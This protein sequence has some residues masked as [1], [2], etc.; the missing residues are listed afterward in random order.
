MFK[1]EDLSLLKITRIK[2]WAILFDYDNKHYFLHG[3]NEEYDE[4]QELYERSLDKNGNYTLKFIKGR[5]G[6]E[7]IKSV[8]IKN[9]YGKS[10][11]YSQIDKE[12]FVKQL[13]R[14]GFANQ[15]TLV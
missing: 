12:F 13:V 4:Y 11:V 3:K 5:L 14:Y 6:A 1:I 2:P 15:S 10:M 8:Y 9:L 7:N